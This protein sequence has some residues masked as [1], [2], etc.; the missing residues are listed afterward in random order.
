MTSASHHSVSIPGTRTRGV[1]ERETSDSERV[2][3]RRPVDP[4]LRKAHLVIG[5]VSTLIGAAALWDGHDLEL[6]GEHRVPGPGFFPILTSAALVA[7]GALLVVRTLLSP[8]VVR[9]DQE[10][11]AGHGWRGVLR[12][13]HVWL[14]YGV[15]ILLLPTLG[16]LAAMALLV[17]YLQLVI[18]RTRGW[19]AIATIV[20]VP[21]CV[22][23]LFDY[24]LGVYLPAGSL[25][26]G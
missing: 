1:A 9:N 6:F 17:A 5:A 12:A 21:M 16:F 3:Q 11:E 2:E 14:G 7:L 20:L 10:A 26:G 4:F 19:R 15:A 22:Y 18:E 24:V 23:G 8:P 13:M 25:F